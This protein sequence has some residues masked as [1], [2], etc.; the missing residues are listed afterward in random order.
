MTKSN[1]PHHNA[2][3]Y[4]AVCTLPSQAK[5]K[6]KQ[7]QALQSRFSPNKNKNEKKIRKSN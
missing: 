2:T 3:H 1:G 4:Q 5:K 7:T 6:K